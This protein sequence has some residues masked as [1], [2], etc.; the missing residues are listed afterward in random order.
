M[1]SQVLA[2]GTDFWLANWI[3]ENAR[4]VSHPG[5]LGTVYVYAGLC[6]ILCLFKNYALT[7]IC[8]KSSEELHRAMFSG[9]IRT[10]VD[11]FNVNSPGKEGLIFLLNLKSLSLLFEGRISAR[12]FKDTG[13][14]DESLAYSLSA[15][16]QAS[17]MIVGIFVIVFIV[18][19]WM[20]LLV[21]KIVVVFLCAKTIF[22]KVAL[23]IDRL[24]ASSK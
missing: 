4:L 2:S 13:V 15:A 18:D 19:L 1:A 5:N 22:S 21:L 23:E 8:G 20:L 24:E 10:S 17:L 14:M 7:R 9:L 3:D 11:F 16:V 12:F 6:V